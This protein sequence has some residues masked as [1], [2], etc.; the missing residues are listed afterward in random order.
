MSRK[1]TYYLGRVVKTGALRNDDIKS[2]LRWP[3]SVTRY[4][5]AWTFIDLRELSDGGS[6]YYFG[7]LG[8]YDPDGEVSVVDPHKHKET[9]QRQPNIT[10]ASSP[11]IYVPE[12][13][14]IAF[15]HV[16]NQIEYSTFMNRWAEVI[17]ASHHQVL[18]RCDV[19]PIADL[20]SFARKLKSLDG[21][22]RVSATVSPPNPLFGPLWEDLKDY[23][24]SRN[25]DRM[26]VEEDSSQSLPLDTNLPEHVAGIVSQSKVQ[27][28]LPGALPIG[29]AA[30]LMAAD[31]YGKG[32]VRGKQGDEV[33]VIRTAETV[34]NFSFSRDP[35]PEELYRKTVGILERIKEERHMEHD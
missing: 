4:G 13:S 10:R 30:I 16:S 1:G 5:S 12:Y 14:G 8:K 31:G 33:I 29:D 32:Y 6:S 7:R 2:A 22:Y 25:T 3:E 19:D 27:P 18:A 21:I 20:R 24:K 17:N 26:K 35:D 11:F 34:R 9:T 28:Y 23:L 15:L